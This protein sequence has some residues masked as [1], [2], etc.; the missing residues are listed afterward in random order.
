[1]LLRHFGPLTHLTEVIP[2]EKLIFFCLQLQA[3]LIL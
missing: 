2:V 3:Q 1:M